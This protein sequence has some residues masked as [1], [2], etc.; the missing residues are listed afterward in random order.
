MKTR[1]TAGSSI[2]VELSKICN[3]D[4]DIITGSNIRKGVLDE[5]HSA[6]WNM[7]RFLTNHPHPELSVIYS[8]MGAQKWSEYK[9]FAF[10]RNP[11]DIAV[12]RYHWTMKGKRGNIETSIDGFREWIV[13]EYCKP[14]GGYLL[15]TL[16]KYTHLNG[17]QVVEFIGRYESLQ[18]DYDRLRQYLD[19]EIPPLSVKLKSGYRDAT[20]YSK[21]Y[22]DDSYALVTE[23]FKEDLENFNYKFEFER[24]FKVTDKKPIIQGIDNNINGPS[25]IRT[26]EL[27]NPLGK[28]YL[29]F[30]N[31]RGKHIRLAYTDDLYGTW[32]VYEGGT[33]QLS[34]TSCRTHIAS[35]DVHLENGIVTMYYHGDIEEGQR[36]F[37][38]TSK[39]GIHFETDNKPLAWFYYRHIPDTT[40]GIAKQGNEGAILYDDFKEMFTLLPSSRH[41]AVYYED[42]TL[43]IVYSIVGE[44]PERLYMMTLDVH[45]WEVFNNFEL[46][47]PEHS[48]EGADLPL[49]PSRFGAVDGRVNQLRDPYIYAEGDDVYLLYSF[50]GESGIAISKLQ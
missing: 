31:H 32:N 27:E 1:K 34:Q 33:L 39:D 47:H 16:S 46:T 15:D 24:E 22:D 41:Y 49:I 7:N 38:A 48:W 50:A 13:S 28:Y 2:Q 25:L 6:G 14:N 8:H 20:H 45:T 35:P 12:S 21:Y 30:A 10:V 18:D 23:Y 40:Y 42:G 17:N 4:N 37:K 43:H 44:A 5:S 9:S 29:Y 11:Y 26:D 19:I 3:P 36:T